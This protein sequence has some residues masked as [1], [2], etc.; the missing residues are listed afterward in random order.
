[1]KSPHIAVAFEKLI[2]RDN[3]YEKMHGL[4]KLSKE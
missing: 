4:P 2:E 1:M 3:L